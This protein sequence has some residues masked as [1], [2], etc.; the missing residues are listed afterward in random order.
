[1]CGAHNLLV[2][3]KLQENSFQFCSYVIA[4]LQI[5][6][7]TRSVRKI[8]KEDTKMRNAVTVTERL[9]IT[10]RYFL[11][12]GDSYT[13]LQYLFKIS[14]QVISK[15]VPKVYQ[16]LIEILKKNIKI[17]ILIHIYLFILFYIFQN[18]IIT[19]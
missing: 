14:K 9:A 10:L 3:L 5:L 17:R 15:I 13:S 7:E 19:L 16:A 4:R 2:D 11:V 12:T 8:K 1:M 6:F 18:L